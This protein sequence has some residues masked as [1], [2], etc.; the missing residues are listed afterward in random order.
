VKTALKIGQVDHGRILTWEEF[1]TSE[2]EDGYRYELIDGR[3]YVSPVPNAPQGLA[4]HWLFTKVSH[5]SLLHPEILNFVHFRARVFVPNR[6]RVTSLEPDVTAYEDFPLDL[7][8]GEVNWQDV[9]PILVAEVLSP[10]D[11]NKDLVRNIPLYLAVPT[12]RE[13]W[14]LDNR[15]NPDQPSLRVFR[16]RGRRWQTAIE[17][18]FGETYTTRLL[19]GFSL[20]LDP[21]R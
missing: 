21:R 13:Y 7:P 9:S 1:A 5:Y 15:T 6:P 10:D 18:G 3:L 20:I 19:P 2:W 16:R 17:M 14:V 8:F 11:P 4:E 12:I